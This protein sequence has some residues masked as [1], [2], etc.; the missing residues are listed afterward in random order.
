LIKS[1]FMNNLALI[2]LVAVIALSFTVVTGTSKVIG[3]GSFALSM[4]ILFLYHAPLSI[5]KQA[6]EEN[7]YLIIM[8]TLV[9]LLGIPIQHGGYFE[10]LQSVF[11]RYV[12]TNS[13]FYLLVSIVSAFIGVLVNMAVV[14]LVHQISQASDRSKNKKLLCSAIS[15]GFTTVT[16]W[17]PTTAAIACIMKLTGTQWT[18]FF[19]FGILLG[20]I[21]GSIGYIMT[22]AEE[23]RIGTTFENSDEKPIQEINMYK[24]VELCLFSLILISAIAIVSLATGISTIIVVSIASLVFP[25]IWLGFIKRLPILLR[26]FKGDYFT[27][28]L[29]KLKNEIVLFVGAGLLETSITY[30]HLGDYIPQL[31][32]IIVGHSALLLAIVVILLSLLLSILGLHPIILVTIIGGTVKAA[33][34]GVSPTYM[35]LI[36]CTSWAMGISISPSAANVIAISGLAELSPIQVGLRWNGSYVLIVSTVLM[37]VLTLFRTIG[38]V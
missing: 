28:S 7:L 16:I 30:S 22:M 21:A 34:Y 4:I 15:R 11:R 6:L 5:W 2:L 38:L 9:P 10:S 1:D 29:P 24:T 17:A 32:N 20:I 3:Y 37:M 25:V 33:A 35:A 26:E 14:P 27:V 13:R 18:V 36:L 31:L 19:P 12:N 23:K 8:F